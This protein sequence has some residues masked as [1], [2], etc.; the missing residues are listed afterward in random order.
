MEG[1]IE[2]FGSSAIQE[3]T[4]GFSELESG[5]I[6]SN[7]LLGGLQEGI[8]DI[9]NILQQVGEASNLSGSN[10]ASRVEEI[11]FGNLNETIQG[12]LKTQE[13]L[14]V[15][16]KY[17]NEVRSVLDDEWNAKFKNEMDDAMGQMR[18]IEPRQER[19]P[20]SERVD[21]RISQLTQEAKARSDAFE[22]EMKRQRL[23]FKRMRRFNR[24]QSGESRRRYEDLR[25]RS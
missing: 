7:Q 4:G 9:D 13:P 2:E 21:S 5:I 3:L 22:L 16:R 1:I 25:P 15:L 12:E 24:E 19:I 20:L 23:R 14:A 8:A 6:S 10:L 17:K 11:D 18:E